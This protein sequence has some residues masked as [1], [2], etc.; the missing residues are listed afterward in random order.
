MVDENKIKAYLTK[1]PWLKIVLNV[2]YFA[3]GKA[4]ANEWFSKKYNIK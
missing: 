2:L 1:F 3:L 4:K